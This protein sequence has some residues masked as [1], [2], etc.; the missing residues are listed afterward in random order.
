MKQFVLIG[1]LTAGATA[2]VGC[3][4]DVHDSVGRSSA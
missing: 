2:L 3:G 1:L 4:S